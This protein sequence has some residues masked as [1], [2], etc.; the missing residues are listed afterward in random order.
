MSLAKKVLILG[1]SGFIGS[2]IAK[3][4]LEERDYKITV[5]D[6]YSRGNKVKS[7]F[8]NSFEINGRLTSLNLDLTQSESFNKLDND[9]DYVFLLAALVGVDK[10]N[11]IPHEV[12]RVNTAITMNVLE[13]LAKASCSRVLFSSTSENYAGTVEKFDYKIPTDESVPLTIEDI[14]HPRFSYAITK[15]LGESGFINYSRAGFFESV[16]VRYHN[17]YGPNMGFRHVIPHLVERFSKNENPLKIYG[18]DQTRSF[19]YISDAVEGT[20]LAIEKGNDRSIYHI[21]SEDEISISDLTK[22]IGELMNYQGEYINA[23]TFP[24][25]VSRRCP[26]ISKAKQDLGYSPKIHWKEGVIK[27]VNWYKSYLSSN[28]NIESFYDQYGVKS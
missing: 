2:S 10:V 12:I 15:I 14:S 5:V 11:K 21:G 26:E 22:F 20:V 13:W 1:G 18:H 23:E 3:F 25:S 28:E 24:G 27:T 16:I 8:F 4:L 7:D 19:N 17:V 9:Y 6:N